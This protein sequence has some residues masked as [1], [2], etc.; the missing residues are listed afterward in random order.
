MERFRPMLNDIGVTE[1][2]WR[3]LRVLLESPGI[4][5]TLLANRA[6]L[7]APSLTRILKTLE[8]RGFVNVSRDP[9]DARRSVLSLTASGRAFLEAALPLMAAIYQD[10][11]DTAGAERIE[12]LLDEVD[13]LLAALEVK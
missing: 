11:E 2:Q 13:A 12:R 7:L 1:Q 5:A 4:D 6:C 3:V 9:R 8:E 10:I